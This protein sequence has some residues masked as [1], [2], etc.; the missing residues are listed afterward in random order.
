METNMLPFINRFMN[1]RASTAQRP[2]SDTAAF[3]RDRRVAALTLALPTLILLAV[4]RPARAQFIL[5]LP[6]NP[7][8]IS[9]STGG[10]VTFTA[11]L[12]N[13][14]PFA[15]YLNSDT[16]TLANPA[17]LDD[18]LFQNTF[19][20]PPNGGAQPTLAANGGTLTLS[21]F[22]VSLP[23]NTPLGIYSGTI[24]LQGGMGQLDADDLDTE[25]F[26]VQAILPTA[27]AP[28][29]PEPGSLALLAGL[30]VTGLAWAVR[31]RLPNAP[32]V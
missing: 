3:L 9:A 18:T 26:A 24:T 27:P 25:Q 11:T 13:N 17:S 5:T 14:N 31:R 16:F 23:A 1:R 28:S 10:T 30:S 7:L 4:S 19:V 15:L 21:L 2:A 22:T 8:V 12:T 6:A 29:V 20:T 32:V